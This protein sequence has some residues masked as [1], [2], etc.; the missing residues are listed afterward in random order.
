MLCWYTL[1]NVPV[2]HVRR[3]STLQL[4]QILLLEVLSAYANVF[5][6]SGVHKSA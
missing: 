2:S 4:W 5:N 6:D 3:Q 1:L